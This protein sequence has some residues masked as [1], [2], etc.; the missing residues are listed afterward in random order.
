ME[1]S[2]ASGENISIPTGF[3]GGGVCYVTLNYFLHHSAHPPLVSSFSTTSDISKSLRGRGIFLLAVM[4]FSRPGNN[5]VRATWWWQTA[6]G[7]SWFQ[8][9]ENRRRAPSSG[10]VT[11]QRRSM[12]K[13]ITFLFGLLC[14][15]VLH[16]S[17]NIS[18][19]CTL[20]RLHM[21]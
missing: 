3:C 15:T 16:E 5:V 6:V 20:L 19:F 1:Q 11:L 21:F 4:V 18:Y 12:W 14:L 10:G 2:S 7:E 8:C 13:P 17:G 9:F